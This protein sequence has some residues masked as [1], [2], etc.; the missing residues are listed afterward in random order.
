MNPDI[1]AQWVGALRSGHYKQ[2]KGRLADSE[3]GFCCLGVLC[4]LGVDA[5][6]ADKEMSDQFGPIYR[7]TADSHDWD[8]NVLPQAVYKWAGLDGRRPSVP[9][10]VNDVTPI[11]LDNLND[12]GRKFDDIADLIE[13]NL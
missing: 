9:S 4:E 10:P 7:S 6:I 2:S 11:T 1:K 3:G 8:R 5:G 12:S 13:A